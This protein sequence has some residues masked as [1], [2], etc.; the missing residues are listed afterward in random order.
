MLYQA[1]LRRKWHMLQQLC[2]DWLDSARL[3]GDLEASRR[4]NRKINE[5]R[6]TLIKRTMVISFFM[7]ITFM[8]T[9]GY[10]WGF[11]TINSWGVLLNNEDW[12]VITFM[13]DALF[14]LV[15][16][17]FFARSNPHLAWVVFLAAIYGTLFTHSLKQLVD[18]FRPAYM[19]DPEIFYIIGPA[20]KKHSFPSGHALTIFT[21]ATVLL[22]YARNLSTR[23]FLIVAAALIGISRVMV[24]VHWPIDVLVGAVGG[25]LATI[26]AVYTTRYWYWGMRI[27]G[28]LF[29]L[30]IWVGCAIALW[31]HDGGYAAASPFAKLFCLGALGWAFYSYIWYPVSLKRKTLQLNADLVLPVIQP[32]MGSSGS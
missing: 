6:I 26:G 32:R 12:Q 13:G 30:F 31:N 4:L 25:G 21:T 8:L 28:H 1:T 20:F 29:L 19:L 23:V 22:Y 7:A 24:G 18:A 27:P 9:H 10:H 17:L 2:S 3:A 14:C 5:A 15:I 16:V 11:L